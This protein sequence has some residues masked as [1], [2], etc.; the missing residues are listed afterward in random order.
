MPDAG[1]RHMANRDLADGR[2]RL[3][4]GFFALMAL[5]TLAVIW[6]DERFWVLPADPR[7]QHFDPIKWWIVPHGLAGTT[8]LIAG[9]AQFSDR[10]RRARPRLHRRLGY[11]YL[12]AVSVAAPI[13][14][15]IGTGPTQPASIHVEQI[16][17]AGLWWLCAAI[18]F[19]CIRRRQIALH[20]AWMMR[21]YAFTLIF[22]L[23]RV[24]DLVVT[25]YSDQ[26]LSD[27]LWALVVLA[28]FAPDAVATARALV[29]P[30]R[31]VPAA[32]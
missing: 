19:L 15:H 21:S 12:G 7:W 2:D 6:V 17:Q 20:K 28:L 25:S 4:W 14:L 26:A 29:R 22:I 1:E 27:L 18:A 3:K 32:G 10:I 16:F 24:P 8:A 31:R 13:A 5:C 30:H 11:V 23:S 9:A